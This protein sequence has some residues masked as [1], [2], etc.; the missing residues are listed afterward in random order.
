MLQDQVALITGA[1]RGLGRE[2]A[3]LLARRGARLVLTARG[4]EALEQ[5]A[6]E[7]RTATSVV[8]LPGDVADPSHAG[9]LVAAGLE[10]FGQIDVLMNNAS[11]LGPTPMQRL[12]DLS[13]GALGKV[14]RVN[15]TAPLV[16]AQLVLP[17]MKA[18]RTGVIVNMTSDAGVQAY[19]GWGAYGVSKAALEHLSRV[20]AQELKGNGIRVYVIDPGE[21][22]TQ[23]YRDAEP[24]VDASQLPGPEVAAA[25]LVDLLSAEDAPFGRFELRKWA[26][27]RDMQRAW[28]PTGAG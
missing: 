15:V 24:G 5:A 3:R 10:R 9:R 13:P 27:V 28:R 26:A 2:T 12:E 11:V 25:T 14:L 20:L 7:A 21:M 8:A 22:N 17:Q 6:E 16:L 19:A 18:R 4:T 23:M 1:S